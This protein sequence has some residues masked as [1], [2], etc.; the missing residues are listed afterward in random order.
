MK[1]VCK[2]ENPS[3]VFFPDGKSPAE[4]CQVGVLWSY[5]CL[6]STPSPLAGKPSLQ[7]FVSPGP[8][9]VTLDHSLRMGGGK[10]KE[11]EVA[12]LCLTLCDPMDGFSVHGIFQARGLEWVAISFSRGSFWPSD[13]TRVSRIAGRR[14]TVWAT[15]E[16]QIMGGGVTVIKTQESKI[17][18]GY[19]CGF[20][21]WG[22][23]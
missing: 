4:R 14:F 18:A 13:R 12:H 10:G 20:G 3:P 5:L 2:H 17:C 11:S 22:V 16:A 15:R 21:S 7:F 1:S 19:W 23:L 9:A 8:G 6:G